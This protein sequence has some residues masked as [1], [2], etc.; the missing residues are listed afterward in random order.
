MVDVLTGPALGNV[1]ENW[2]V[3]PREDLYEWIRN[4]QKMINDGHPRAIELW[5]DWQPTVMNNFNLTDEEIE[6]LLVYIDAK[7]STP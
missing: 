5:K 7:S 4:S 3:Y 6:H 1:E 2:A